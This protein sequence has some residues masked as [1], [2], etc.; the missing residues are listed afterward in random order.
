MD[1]IGVVCGQGRKAEY[2]YLDWRGVDYD[3]SYCS[4]HSS[5]AG[6]G[7]IVRGVKPTGVVVTRNDFVNNTVE[8]NP[9][10]STSLFA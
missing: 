3:G 4:C 5:V 2:V 7:I 6:T 8:D 1:G 10:W 9:P